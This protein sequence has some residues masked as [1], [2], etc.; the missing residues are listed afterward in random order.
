MSTNLVVCEGCGRHVRDDEGAC[1]FCKAPAVSRVAKATL[2]AAIT[3]AAGLSLQACYGGPPRPR[4]YS[5]EQ[6][7]PGGAVTQVAADPA[8]EEK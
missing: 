1:P 8:A 6:H 7:R 4:T 2:V 3:V 5:F